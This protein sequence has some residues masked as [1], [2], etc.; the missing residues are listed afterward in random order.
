MLERMYTPD[1]PKR[2]DWTLTVVIGAIGLVVVVVL[3]LVGG[4]VG[5]LALRGGDTPAPAPV[6]SALP[7]SPSPAPSPSPS[8]EVSAAQCLLGDW[9]ETS[10]TSTSSL[11]GQTV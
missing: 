5:L 2:R 11:F 1:P 3:C 9:V 7:V 4:G 8:P 6:A 10:N